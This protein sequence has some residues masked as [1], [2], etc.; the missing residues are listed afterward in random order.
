VARILADSDIQKLLGDVIR[1]GDPGLINPNGIELRLGGHARFISTGEIKEIPPDHFL[2][3]PPGETAIIVSLE[4]IDFSRETVAE[5]FKGCGIMGLITPTT[6]MMREGANLAST[7]VDQGFEGQLNWGIRNGSYKDLI[8]QRGEPI[9]KLT[10][11]LLEG[12][13]VPS[14]SYG[15]RAGDKYQRTDGIRISTRRVPADIP[16]SLLVTSSSEKVDPK[17]H[18][19]EA[20]YPFN[21]IGSEL[22]RLDGKFELV[23]TDVRALT[24]KMESDTKSVLTKIDDLKTWLVDH[25]DTKFTGK[26]TVIVGTLVTA[27]SLT[28]AAYSLSQNLNLGAAVT[29]GLFGLIGVVA[30]VITAVLASRR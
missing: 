9:F 1:D 2:Q 7:K 27:G 30:L 20:G 22:I 19:R 18:L 10:L 29:A 11:L 12:D 14:L 5:H 3:I 13:E 23:S 6:T 15:E 24:Q 25:V 26:F 8:I 28:V 21:H 17:T 16:R 4:S